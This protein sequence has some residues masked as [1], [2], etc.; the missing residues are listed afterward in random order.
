MEAGKKYDSKI[1]KIVLGLIKKN[2][3]NPFWLN[4]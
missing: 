1:V 3:G 2:H 4:Y